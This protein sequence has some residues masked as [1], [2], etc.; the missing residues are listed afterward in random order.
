MEPKKVKAILD[1]KETNWHFIVVSDD[2]M[3][4]MAKEDKKRC[5]QKA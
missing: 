3:F 5:K 1:S 4:K 2:Y